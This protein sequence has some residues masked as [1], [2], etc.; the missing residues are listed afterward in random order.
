[1]PRISSDKS[2]VLYFRK[3]LLLKQKDFLDHD[4]MRL[5]YEKL[6]AYNLTKLHEDG[7]P[8]DP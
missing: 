4:V 2:N 5:K 8:R 1:M 3:P 6:R 7:K